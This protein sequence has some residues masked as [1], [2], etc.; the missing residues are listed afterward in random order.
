MKIDIIELN[1]NDEVIAFH[2]VGNMSPREINAYCDKLMPKLDSIF[3]K[4]NNVGNCALFPV[5]EGETWDFTVIR[6]TNS[7]T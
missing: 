5:R 2:N 7:N 4:R 6:R 3:G 1:P